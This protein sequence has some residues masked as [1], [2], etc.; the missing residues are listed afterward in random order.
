M[1][2]LLIL[3]CSILPP[4][5]VLVLLAIVLG[6]RLDNKPR[7]L[8]RSEICTLP[9]WNGIRPGEMSID[10]ANH[11]LFSQGYEAQNS[12]M[13]RAH[14]TY[15]PVGLGCNVR[16]EYEEATVT[17]TR[18][19]NCPN[20]RLGDV[21]AALGDPDS[22]LP[23]S[24]SFSFERGMAR[25]R[26]KHDPCEEKLSPYSEVMYVQFSRTPGILPNEVPWQGFIPVWRYGQ[27]FPDTIPLV[28]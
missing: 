10:A 16:L 14:I 20:L 12:L 11:I 15:T 7:L 9:C 25:L 4:L 26:L 18:L 27:R 8:R 6:S 19:T 2:R 22:L 17:E 23:H 21:I 5:V 13:D 24:S 1:K 3:Q 28:C